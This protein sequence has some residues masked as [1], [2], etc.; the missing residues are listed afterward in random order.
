MCGGKPRRKTFPS[1]SWIRVMCKRSKKTF[2]EWE[3]SVWEIR[4]NVNSSSLTMIALLNKDYLSADWKKSVG[5]WWL[6]QIKRFWCSVDSRKFLFIQ[7][8]VFREFLVFITALGIILKRFWRVL[9]NQ[10]VEVKINNSKSSTEIL[11]QLSFVLMSK[12]GENYNKFRWE[13][14]PQL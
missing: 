11:H 2:H 4:Q 5:R 7:R 9:T 6:M 3:F 13:S 10:V 14:D 1:E 12:H 8:W